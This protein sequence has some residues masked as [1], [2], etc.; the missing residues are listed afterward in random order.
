MRIERDLCACGARPQLPS[1]R[2]VESQFLRI[3]RIKT[4]AT[5]LVTAK[6]ARSTNAAI[7][8][9]DFLDATGIPGRACAAASLMRDLI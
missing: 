2:V 4:Q 1:I 9:Y 5:Q 6:D 7:H 3:R 8:E